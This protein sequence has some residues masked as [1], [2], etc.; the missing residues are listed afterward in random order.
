MF[1]KPMFRQTGMSVNTSYEA[2][3]FHMKIRKMM[4][5]K[6]PIESITPLI[7]TPR[8]EGVIPQYDIRTDKFEIAMEAR[9]SI[10]A[11]ITAKVKESVDVK[12]EPNKEPEKE[13][14]PE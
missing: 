1:R 12:E 6:E 7:Y 9:N 3:H 8:K 14:K 11:T 13:T 4:E 2:E 5:N 10:D